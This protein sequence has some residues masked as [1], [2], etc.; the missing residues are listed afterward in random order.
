ME[1]DGTTWV[2]TGASAG[3]GEAIA[4]EAA[5]RGAKVI[6]LARREGPLSEAMRMIDG[7]PLVADV[8]DPTVVDGLVDR[9]EAEHGPVDVWVNNAGIETAAAL[10][11]TDADVVRSIVELNLIAPIELCRQVIPRMLGRGKGHVVNISSMASS[12]GFA[13]MS[14][15]VSTKSG[16]SSFHRVLRGEMKGT[17]VGLTIAELGP[18][19]TPMLERLYTVPSAE[20]GFRRMRRL[21]LL[22]E[23][24]RERVAEEIVDA[25]ADGRGTVRLPKRAVAFPWLSAT[26]QRVVDLLVIGRNRRGS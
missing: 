10:V 9:I 21:Q 7:V 4:Q 15:Y 25:V 17:P 26:P 19:P 2:V 11:D 12:A 16:L 6:G 23:I 14:L 3:I 1:I 18:I 5:R 24:P 8:G 22:P 20:R 13:G